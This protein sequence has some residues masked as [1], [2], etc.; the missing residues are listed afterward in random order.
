MINH[1]HTHIIKDGYIDQIG[2]VVKDIEK[3]SSS[4]QKLFGIGPFPTFDWPDDVG[5]VNSEYYGKP[6]NWKMKL[7]FANIGQMK[8]ELIQP[9]SGQSIFMDFLREHGPGL[10][11]FRYIVQDIEKSIADVKKMGLKIISR[12]KGVHK[13][14]LWAFIDTRDILDG[15][16]VELRIKLDE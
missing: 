3:V 12:G 10:H 4:F 8:L 7:V 1:K 14:S 2:I 6:G 16:I 9:I 11:H 5:V 13:G 15:V